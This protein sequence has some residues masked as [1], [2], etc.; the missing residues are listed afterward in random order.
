MEMDKRKVLDDLKSRYDELYSE[1]KD[2][3][4][5]WKG[6]FEGTPDYHEY[7]RLK[8][9]AVEDSSYEVV[10]KDKYSNWS[11]LEQKK[12]E[13]QT[14]VS[15]YE[16]AVTDAARDVYKGLSKEVEALESKLEANKKYVEKLKE[17]I[18]AKKQQIAAVKDSEAYKNGDQATLLEVEGLEEELAGKVSRKEK[19]ETSVKDVEKE[20]ELVSKERD[21]M[22]E[23]YGD[24]ITAEPDV[25]EQGKDEE[26]LEPESE[27]DKGK[28][29]KDESR[30]ESSPILPDDPEAEELTPE[31]KEQKEF[32]DLYKKALI[33]K[34]S[35]EDF[36]KLVEIMKNPES[37][38]KYDITTGTVFNK[39]RKITKALKKNIKKPKVLL[40][41]IDL[42]FPSTKINIW[43]MSEKEAFDAVMAMDRET[44]TPDQ[45]AVYDKIS[46][47]L[48]KKDRIKEVKEVAKA[49]K[50]ERTLKKFSWLLE[51][52]EEEK[53]ALTSAP[54]STTEMKTTL[55]DEL[56]SKTVPDAE[57]EEIEAKPRTVDDPEQT[58]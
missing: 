44:L 16:K 9:K 41:D 22:I 28:G 32:D 56:S 2:F 47:N 43:K 51:K 49:V 46:K 11:D 13:I 25:P 50:D 55:G 26:E 29:K 58:K 20:L 45:Q 48:S 14:K 34:L 31:Q 40:K 27:E 4:E 6:D 12:A 52:D 3:D 53:P 8:E 33:G 7:M 54:E 38:D 19:I 21:D 57:Y 1:L 37:Y 42:K 18:E 30:S 5:Q 23:E 24:E 17:E 10:L 35:E 36:D 39:S 15:A